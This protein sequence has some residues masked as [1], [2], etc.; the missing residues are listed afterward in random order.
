MATYNISTLDELQAMS[1]HRGDDCIL[2][3]DIDAEATGKWNLTNGTYYG[4]EPIGLNAA[5][6]TGTFNGSGFKIKNL[7][8]NRTTIDFVAFLGSVDRAVTS[9]FI[10]DVVLENADI[11]G[12][13]SVAVFIGSINTGA[14]GVMAVS[15]V[16]VNLAL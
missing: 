4:F 7:Y 1:S 3:N 16:S 8:I 2:L 6:F 14:S 5:R 9:G 12:R 11:T 15:N 13:S 10:K